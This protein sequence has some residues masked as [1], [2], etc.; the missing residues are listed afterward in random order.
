MSPL[1]SYRWHPDFQVSSQTE[2][3]AVEGDTKAISKKALKPKKH[4]ARTKE[5]ALVA[6]VAF[7]LPSPYLQLARHDFGLDSGFKPTPGW[8]VEGD[9]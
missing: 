5:A 1:R 8:S 3:S 4:W 9:Q 2:V 6:L 7:A